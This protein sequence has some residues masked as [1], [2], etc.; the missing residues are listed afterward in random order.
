[1]HHSIN[2]AFE[3]EEASDWSTWWLLIVLC[4]WRGMQHIP[5][6]NH[7]TLVF[8]SEGTCGMFTSMNSTWLK[9]TAEVRGELMKAWYKSGLIHA[10]PEIKPTLNDFFFLATIGKQRAGTTTESMKMVPWEPEAQ[11]SLWSTCC[12]DEQCGL[13]EN[14]K[15]SEKKPETGTDWVVE[16]LK[17]I[18]A[19]DNCTKTETAC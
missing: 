7:R 16:P 2:H 14:F 9:S 19:I 17:L 15:L 5:I 10:H 3:K 13:M 4:L 1:M 6:C 18:I 8:A 12:M 11:Y